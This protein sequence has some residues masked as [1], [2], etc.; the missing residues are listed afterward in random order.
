LNSVIKIRRS[1]NEAL[2]VVIT[3]V[4]APVSSSFD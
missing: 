1:R 3:A 2:A 4:F